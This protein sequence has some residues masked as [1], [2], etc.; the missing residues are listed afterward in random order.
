[1][2]GGAHGQPED[3]CG[4]MEGSTVA[5]L[6]LGRWAGV[7]TGGKNSS[8]RIYGFTAGEGWYRAVQLYRIQY[9]HSGKLLC[10]VN[11][12]KTKLNI[13]FI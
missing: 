11:G 7:S 4:W 6:P 5:G 12:V 13:Q 10:S 1:M 2:A 8:H 9:S 3:V